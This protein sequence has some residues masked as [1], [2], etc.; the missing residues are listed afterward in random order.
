MESVSSS[1]GSYSNQDTQPYEE[2]IP[3][4]EETDEAPVQERVSFSLVIMICK[5]KNIGVKSLMA[6]SYFTLVVR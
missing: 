2:R 3:Q 6:F 1:L 4:Q 5:K